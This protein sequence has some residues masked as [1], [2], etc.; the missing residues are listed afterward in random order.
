MRKHICQSGQTV[1]APPTTHKYLFTDLHSSVVLVTPFTFS[2]SFSFSFNKGINLLLVL[3][4][5]I[6]LLLALVL[7]LVR[8]SI[9]V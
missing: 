2:F 1:T 6:N 9:Y 3:V 4:L 8:I 5:D 7:G